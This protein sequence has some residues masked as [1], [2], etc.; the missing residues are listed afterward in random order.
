MR[1][2]ISYIVSMRQYRNLNI[3][4][5]DRHKLSVILVHDRQKYM[6]FVNGG[7]YIQ[8]NMQLKMLVYNRQYKQA[9]L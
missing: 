2:L 1:H 5:Y 9:Y 3:L 7:Q 8:L 6:L 4:A